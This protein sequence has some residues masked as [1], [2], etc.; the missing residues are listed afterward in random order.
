MFKTLDEVDKLSGIIYNSVSNAI[1]TI[2]F[3]SV[4]DEKDDT[5]AVSQD[6]GEYVTGSILIKTAPAI[7]SMELLIPQDFLEKISADII[8]PGTK[9]EVESSIVIDIAMELLNTIAG[10]LMRNVEMQVGPFVLEIPEFE[11]GKPISTRAFIVKR[12]TAAGNYTITVAIT[13][14]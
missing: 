7:Y 9:S 14:I 2:T 6:I 12:Y 11:I 3:I 10:S 4:N 8:V 1:E 13:K 5:V